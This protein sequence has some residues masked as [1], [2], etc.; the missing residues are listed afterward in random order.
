MIDAS[1][2][3]KTGVDLPQGKNLVGSFKQPSLVLIDPS[4]LSTLPDEEARNGAAEAIKHGVIASPDLFAT[5]ENGSVPFT[6]NLIARILKVKVRIVE[7][8]PYERGQRETLNLGHTV[9]HAIEQ[10]SK[11]AVPHGR[12]VGIGR[13]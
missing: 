11:F 1:V 6:P 7:K 2:G 10:V 12:A 8:D 5:L 4:V 9:G 13:L 3:G